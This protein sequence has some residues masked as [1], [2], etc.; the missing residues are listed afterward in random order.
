MGWVQH[1]DDTKWEPIFTNWAWDGTKWVANPATWFPVLTVIGTWAD[2]YRPTKVRIAFT[3]SPDYMR[4]A[5]GANF[6]H[7]VNDSYASGIE[8]D[9]DWTDQGA[10]VM[11]DIYGLTVGFIASAIRTITNIEFYEADTICSE[12][13]DG[14]LLQAEAL[15]H[16]VKTLAP[17][18]YGLNTKSTRQMIDLDAKI[19]DL[20]DSDLARRNADYFRKLS[21]QWVHWTKYDKE[22]RKRR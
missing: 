18:L 8:V 5:D 9:L 21:D 14:I 7:Y 22:A 19:P 13:L 11:T 3:G 10:H 1:F 20:Q 17:S 15:E 12:S 6:A 16:Y 4:V 2:A